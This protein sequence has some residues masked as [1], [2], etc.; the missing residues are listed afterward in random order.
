MKRPTF[1]RGALMLLLVN[2]FTR[3]LGF[4]Y[5]ALAVRLLGAEGIGLYEMVFPWYGLALVLT[6]AG[7]PLALARITAEATARAECRRAQLAFTATLLTVS[8]AGAAS[9]LA[10]HRFAPDLARY[11]LPDPRTETVL[12]A[13]VPALVVV[14]IASAFRGWFQGLGRL[15]LPA[16]A[17]AAEQVS[18]VLLGLYLAARLLPRGLEAAASG[19]AWGMVAGEMVGLGCLLLAY[20]R[21]S[22]LPEGGAA[23]NSGLI[24]IWLELWR[25]GW[26]V[27]LGRLVASTTLTLEAALIPQRL[28]AAGYSLRRATELYGQF[29]GV[30]MTLLLLPTVL[31]LSLATTAVPAVA[32]AVARNHRGLLNRRINDSLR[33]SLLGGLPFAVTYLLF[34]HQLAAFLF[35]QA[36]AGAPLR[37][38]AAGAVFIYLQQ[39]STGILQGLGRPDLATR[40]SLLGAGLLLAGVYWLTALP[41][42]GLQGAAMAVVLSAVAGCYLNLRS[43]ARLTG[44][45]LSATVVVRAVAAGTVM[46]AVALWI[47]RFLDP[48]LSSV[49]SLF[50]ALVPATMAYLLAALCT[51]VLSYHDLV[52]LLRRPQ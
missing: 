34:P 8:V 6:T 44:T 1:A 28:Q 17:Q 30:A 4:T 21:I 10:F 46:G 39:T 5:R 51:G 11:L 19:L 24:G 41:E 16:A 43:I 9:A 45:F 36:R 3:L 47:Y 32:E 26:P 42:A 38:L 27:T 50:G 33:L 2:L 13:I 14:P 49:V 29:A 52:R 23:I 35:D 40:N 31:T 7:F 18:R 22:P 48:S 20:R 25:L 15:D 12:T 37:V